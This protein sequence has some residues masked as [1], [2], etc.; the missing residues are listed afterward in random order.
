MTDTPKRRSDSLTPADNSPSQPE[1]RARFEDVLAN[2]STLKDDSAFISKSFCPENMHL[3]S[4]LSSDSRSN[5]LILHTRFE[6]SP[7]KDGIVILKKAPFPTDPKVLQQSKLVHKLLA[8]SDHS[9]ESEVNPDPSNPTITT[10]P[11]W[12]ATSILSNDVYHRLLVTAGLESLNEV[13]MTV[14][15][16][17][18]PHHFKRYTKSGRHMIQETPELYSSVIVP[19]LSKTP[20]DLSWVDNILT[21]KAERDRVLFTTDLSDDYGFTLVLD[22]RWNEKRIQEM[23]CLGIA[24]DPQLTCLRDLRSTHIPMLKKILVEG[25]RIL[26]QKYSADAPT[27]GPIREDQIMAYVHYP[28]TFY[29]LHVHFVHVDAA[30]DGGTRTGRAHLL[31]EVIRN[32]E[33][34]G[35]YYANRVLTIYLHDQSPMLEAVQQSFANSTSEHIGSENVRSGNSAS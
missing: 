19:F 15:H 2:N 20:R 12:Q 8:S 24:H 30:D 4:V 25:R 14:I 10:F 23:H 33:L 9:T 13:D 28:P 17:A 7:D 18:G 3:V 31:D 21:G 32:L 6:D 29:R 1:K 11:C 16:P 5:C 35:S 22:Y 27:P 34:D 26:S